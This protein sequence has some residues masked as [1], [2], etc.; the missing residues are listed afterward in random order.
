MKRESPVTEW[1]AATYR[2]AGPG[3]GTA[4]G[5]GHRAA[6]P[7]RSRPL[8]DQLGRVQ[9]PHVVQDTEQHPLSGAD[10]LPTSWAGYRDRTWFRTP[11]STPC[12]EPATYRPAGPGTGTARG[13]GHR[14]APPVRSRPLTDQLGRVQGPHVV[15][16]TEQHPL[17][18]ADHLPTSWAG[19]RD[20]TWFRTP[21]STPCPEPATYRPAGPG[22]G[23]A[24]GSG[25]RAAPPVRSRPL[26]DQLGRV[27]G[28]HVV[29]DT[30]QHP[31]STADLADHVIRRD[32]R[33]TKL[34]LAMDMSAYQKWTFRY[35]KQR[36]TKYQCILRKYI[37]K[38]RRAA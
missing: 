4:R 2:P 24:R 13:S 11:S 1:C 38:L 15:Q 10:H 17:S 25:H 14:A 8:T 6:P 19:Y 12:P 18:G 35:V 21:S 9:G 33:V 22:T 34:H 32:G 16:D 5:S 36:L 7:V 31:L 29:Q 30:E 28:P 26:T 27:Q 23:T 3:T 37:S 20:R